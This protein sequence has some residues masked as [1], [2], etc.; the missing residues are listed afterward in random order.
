ME[1]VHDTTEGLRPLDDPPTPLLS[2]VDTGGG[3]RGGAPPSLQWW[4]RRL[5]AVERVLAL[6]FSG[7]GESNL[8][9]NHLP[10]VPNFAPFCQKSLRDCTRPLVSGRSSPEEEEDLIR[11]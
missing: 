5:S 7:K 6:W 4:R 2:L 8:K 11:S 9:T 3:D 1:V 10:V